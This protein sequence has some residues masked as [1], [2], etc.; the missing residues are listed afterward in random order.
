MPLKPLSHRAAAQPVNQLI[1]GRHPVRTVLRLL[2]R[3]RGRVVL[4]VLC[5]AVK[6]TPLWLMPVVTAGIIDVV[7]D[8]G[9]LST[10]WWWCAVAVIALLQNYPNH[11][12]YTR[13]FMGAVRQVGADL[14]NGLA[15]QLQSLSI[16]FHSRASSSVVQTKVVRDVENIEVM[17]QQVAHPLL[18]AT[19]V[20]GGAVVMIALNVPA[21]LAVYALVLPIAVALRY[22]LVRRSRQADRDDVQTKEEIGRA[23]V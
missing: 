20:L 10:L 23:H 11:V 14:R 16:G 8:G 19:M 5:F 22:V 2:G 17:L 21:F 12:L 15:A 3:Y 9:P 18:S 7:V 6:D 4:A 13:F 1:D